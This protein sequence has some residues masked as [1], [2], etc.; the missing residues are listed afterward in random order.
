M[1]QGTR[2]EVLS[3]LSFRFVY[4]DENGILHKHTHSLVSED[5]KQDAFLTWAC[6]AWLLENNVS[7]FFSKI[8]II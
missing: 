1:E 2:S 8:F 3:L 4:R 7:F 5:V 6:L